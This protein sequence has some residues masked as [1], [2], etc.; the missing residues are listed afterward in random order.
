MIGTW[1]SDNL[2]LC[3]VRHRKEA[4]APWGLGVG[5][6]RDGECQLFQSSW[7]NRGRERGSFDLAPAQTQAS[8]LGADSDLGP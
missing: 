3:L 7:E 6:Q 5:S 8:C 4:A 2:R 1:V